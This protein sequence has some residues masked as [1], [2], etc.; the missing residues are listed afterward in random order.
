M[1]R[2]TYKSDFFFVKFTDSLFNTCSSV[3]DDSKIFMYAASVSCIVLSYSFLAWIFLVKL[4]FIFCNFSLKIEIS[5]CI[6]ALSSS[7]YNKLKDAAFCKTYFYDRLVEILAF[8]PEFLD[9]F[10]QFIVEVGC[11]CCHFFP[12]PNGKYRCM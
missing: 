5:R 10:H 3:C 4:S 6:L 11:T 8:I 12:M 9:T 2:P 7:S 1:T